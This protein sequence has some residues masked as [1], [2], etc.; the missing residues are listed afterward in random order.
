LYGPNG[1][2]EDSRDLQGDWRRHFDSV[3]RRDVNTAFTLSSKQELH[4]FNRSLQEIVG[5]KFPFP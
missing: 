4:F 5:D 3:Y 2:V 1:G